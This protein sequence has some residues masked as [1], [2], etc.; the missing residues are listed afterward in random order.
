M[1]VRICL[2]GLVLLAACGEDR[3]VGPGT[4][5][6][7]DV[8]GTDAA[9]LTPPDADVADAP[10]AAE[11]GSD[12][13]DAV[14]D[15]A[16]DGD[17]AP[18]DGAIADNTGDADDALDATGDADALLADLMADVGVLELPPA[19]SAP[20]GAVSDDAADATDAALDETTGSDA[21]AAL[22]VAVDLCAGV[23]CDDGNACTNDACELAGSCT[24][25]ASSAACDDGNPC[26]V[27]DACAGG[28]CTG[29]GDA[30]GTMTWGTGG[31][32]T[33]RGL[34][35][36]LAG[37]YALGGQAAPG[38]N[39]PT[40]M[41]LT[42]TDA[43]GATLWT[44]TYGGSGDAGGAAIAAMADGGF[45]LAGWTTS[46]GAGGKDFWTVRIDA[47]GAIL[48]DKV[49]GG[50]QDDQ[51][52]GVAATSDGGA[53]VVG[54]RSD[55][56]GLSAALV[57]YGADGSELW[58]QSFGAGV[59]SGEAVLQTAD[60]GFAF[61]GSNWANTAQLMD[62]WLVK[63]D[64]N[65]VK[66]WDTTYG[67][68][69][70]D[71]LLSFAPGP[72]GGFALT[73][74][75]YSKGAGDQD[76]W[77]VRTDAGGKLLWD[78]AFGGPGGD[79]CEAVTALADGGFALTGA[80]DIA[81]PA[82]AAFWLLRVDAL[83]TL[84]WQDKITPNSL[85]ATG[86]AV[87]ATDDLGHLAAAGYRTTSATHRDALLL[88]TDAFGHSTCADSGLCLPIALTTCDDA[89]VCTAAECHAATGCI[90]VP[91]AVTGCDD[92]NPCTF[93]D[94]C[95]GGVCMP[96]T[97]TPCDD[98]NPCTSDLC[99]L[100]GGCSHSFAAVGTPCAPG[101]SCDG[102]GACTS[103]TPTDMVLIPGG[104]F[105]M[106]CNSAED[107]ACDFLT[108]FPQHK[109]TVSP[110]YIDPNE[111]TVGQYKACVDAG[112]CTAPAV[113][114]PA[115]F[116]TYPGLLNFP[117][118]FISQAQARQF[119]QW[120]GPSYDLPT[121]AQWELA[122]RGTCTQNGSASDDP[123]CTS[124]MR[125]YPWGNAVATC[126]YA[127]MVG[128]NPG[129]GTGLLAPV[130]TFVAGDSPFGVHDMAGNVAEWSR[131]WIATSYSYPAEAQT[132]PVGPTSG[133]Y[134]LLRGG[135]FL[136]FAAGL[137]ASRRNIGDSA[138][139]SAE[140]GVRCVRAAP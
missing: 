1:T 86:Y 100:T 133:I 16:G 120:R 12:G 32:L 67:G 125:V 56:S 105:W 27:G 36:T 2:V 75:T 123:G 98:G 70:T 7:A 82:N 63:V 83:G 8:A 78:A 131:D 87:L 50:G 129:C 114:Q 130:G 51:A 17:A 37:G 48:W 113:V 109:V 21:D 97:Q 134:T 74:M 68:T 77:L 84:R 122:A 45:V 41:W 14:A 39:S 11:A 111:V 107:N 61:A 124:A 101:G 53:I 110:Y 3:A 28:Q 128:S 126:S 118:N 119:C 95:G 140:D 102:S 76:C 103:P 115:K 18:T 73:G 54:T 13:V 72:G 34:V 60:G 6:A 136:D 31:S 90:S 71:M 117:V 69:Q 85:D 35:R 47:A 66:Q 55:G 91:A 59:A 108:E 138:E 89:D 46:T 57:R 88:R 58:S 44:K 26:T 96:G 99:S 64:G 25:T 135:G 65:G 106:G 93:G 81:N 24:H 23:T 10:P 40:V 139:A 30:L 22:D 9:A 38:A 112:G 4:A 5:E 49:F 104:T 80:A 94:S 43:A 116:A 62:F 121:D 33:A 79:N 29:G 42:V 127:V 15:E 19:D 92:G 132:D 52:T 137:R 20:D